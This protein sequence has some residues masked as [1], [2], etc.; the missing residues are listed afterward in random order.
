M[1]KLNLISRIPIQVFLEI[2]SEMKESEQKWQI[3]I[4]F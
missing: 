3:L 1:E 4:K 2:L